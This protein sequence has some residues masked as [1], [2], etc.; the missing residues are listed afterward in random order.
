M[1]LFVIRQQA[2][3]LA[4]SQ[5]NFDDRHDSDDSFGKHQVSVGNG[6]PACCRRCDKHCCR[7]YCVVKLNDSDDQCI[8]DARILLGLQ[9]LEHKLHGDAGRKHSNDYRCDRRPSS[10][11][12]GCRKPERNADNKHQPVH[13]Q[14]QR[15]LRREVGSRSVHNC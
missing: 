15:R 9:W 1:Q 10:H 13:H 4:C 6:I 3:Y 2:V 7:C 11:S 12:D 5:H 8:F 14:E